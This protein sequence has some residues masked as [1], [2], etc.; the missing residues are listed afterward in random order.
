MNNMNNQHNRYN[1]NLADLRQ[2]FQ[3]PI[4]PNMR[5]GQPQISR[6]K[7]WLIPVI[8]TVIAA[9]LAVTGVIIWKVVSED[10]DSGNSS[11]K[12]YSGSSYMVKSKAAAANSAAASLYNAVNTVLTELD[13]QGIDIAG[14]EYISY[15]KGDDAVDI[16]GNVRGIDGKKIYVSVKEYFNDVDKCDFVVKIDHGVCAAAISTTDNEYWGTKP[17][18][19]KADDYRNAGSVFTLEDAFKRFDDFA[20]EYGSEFSFRNY[21]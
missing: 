8:I 14:L 4:N 21:R 18:V 10:K 2:G 6:K 5:Q 3:Q 11:K 9:V 13:E 17:I 1:P 12:P 15:S 7:K 19:F 20:Y 16:T